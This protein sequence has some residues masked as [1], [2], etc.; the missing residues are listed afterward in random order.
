LDREA[1][2]QE[3]VVDNYCQSLKLGAY[4]IKSEFFS[5]EQRLIFRRRAQE[6]HQLLVSKGM[7]SEVIKENHDPIF[8]SHPGIRRTRD[9]IALNFWWPGMSK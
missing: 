1:V 2:R 5:D 3:Q 9:L 6:R 8:A 4:K 7:I